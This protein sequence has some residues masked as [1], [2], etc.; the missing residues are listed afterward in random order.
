MNSVVMATVYRLCWLTCSA[1]VTASVEC[2]FAL[3]VV[4]LPSLCSSCAV[5]G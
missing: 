4:L 3:D 1:S 5:G 2:L